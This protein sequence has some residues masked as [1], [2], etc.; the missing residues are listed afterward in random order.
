MHIYIYIH[1]HPHAHS[2]IKSTAV[3]TRNWLQF[4]YVCSASCRCCARHSTMLKTPHPSFLR[5]NLAWIL[6]QTQTTNHKIRFTATQ[7]IKTMQHHLHLATF[8]RLSSFVSARLLVQARLSFRRSYD[9]RLTVSSICDRLHVRFFSLEQHK[10]I[11]HNRWEVLG[12][13]MPIQQP[14][15]A[16]W[17]K[18]KA[19]SVMTIRNLSAL[20]CWMKSTPFLCWNVQNSTHWNFHR[21]LV[22]CVLSRMLKIY[23]W[24]RLINS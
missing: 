12:N 19:L 14:P 17:Y 7:W 2:H 16:R 21:E 15:R 5:G 3:R 10:E 9:S 13:Y 24:E 20:I 8:Q 1:T 6:I 4:T 18:T 11:K 23:S 22:T